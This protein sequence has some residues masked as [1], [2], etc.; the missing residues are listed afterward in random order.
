MESQFQKWV[1]LSY[2]ALAI[3]LGYIVFAA[4]MQLGGLLD[5]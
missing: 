3:L 2:L 4:S 5:L 1:N